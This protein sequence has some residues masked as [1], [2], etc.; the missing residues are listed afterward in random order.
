MTIEQKLNEALKTLQY[1]AD[2]DNYEDNGCCS[3]HP[4]Y[5]VLDDEGHKARECLKKLKEEQHD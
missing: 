3:A 4:L 1:Y 2:L 5:P